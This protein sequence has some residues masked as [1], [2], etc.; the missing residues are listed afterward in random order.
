LGNEF[1]S[2][3]AA[4]QDFDV[5]TQRALLVKSTTTDYQDEISITTGRTL[6]IIGEN[7]P[8]LVGNEF[9][10]R[11]V[12]E[13]LVS[14]S[15]VTVRNAVTQP[16]TCTS[17]G[18]LF[19]DDVLVRDSP[20]GGVFAEGCRLLR[21]TKSRVFGNDEF[22]ISIADDAGP[23]ARGR[24]EMFASAV[25]G[26]GTSTND[27][28]GL[29]IGR[30]IDFEIVASSIVDNVSM[31]GGSAPP[32][33]NLECPDENDGV[34]RNS[35]V[36]GPGG[37]G[38]IDCAWASFE[39]SVIDEATGAMMNSAVLG[40]DGVPGFD[41]AWFADPDLGVVTLTSPQNTPFGGVA[42]WRLGDPRYD[43]N[44]PDLR[45]PLDQTPEFAGA[46]QP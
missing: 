11:S 16:V 9:T 29:I 46:D 4:L 19:L 10:I 21:L 39:Y 36:A 41:S 24:L 17:G 42:L 12:S 33:T 31:G 8:D 3:T 44:D 2:I 34:V 1:C 23:P 18:R 38:T 37:A 20:A 43:I 32:P 14:L 5:D 35:I 30:D 6:A 13:G 28:R 45:T 15:R 7:R 40:E 22:G 26:N 27:G 25:S